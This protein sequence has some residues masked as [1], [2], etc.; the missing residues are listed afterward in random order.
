MG[1]PFSATS[2]TASRTGGGTAG[3]CSTRDTKPLVSEAISV[4]VRDDLRDRHVHDAAVEYHH[5][6]ADAKI[7]IGSPS[8]VRGSSGSV[9]SGPVA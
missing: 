6:C 1:I 4:E 2:A 8:P 9:L 5:D 3:F 7:A